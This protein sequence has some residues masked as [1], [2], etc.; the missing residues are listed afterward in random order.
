MSSPKMH[1]DELSIDET[2]VSSLIASQFPDWSDLLLTSVPSAGTDNALFRLGSNMV[3]RLP[4][5]KSAA[6]QVTKDFKWLPKLAPQLPLPVSTPLVLGKPT[7]ALPWN[8][9]VCKWLPGETPI[10]GEITDEERLAV[11]LANFVQSLQKIDPLNGPRPGAHNFGR[12]VP[13]LKR[14]A[15]VRAALAELDDLIDVAAATKEW[16]VSL[17]AA[18]WPKDRVWVHGDLQAGNLLLSKGR[19][20]AVIDFGG[21]GVGDP[22]V[23][24]LPAWNMFGGSARHTYRKALGV[25]EATWTR[26]RGWA[27]SVALIALPYYYKSNPEIVA[28]SLHVIGELLK[29]RE[30]HSHSS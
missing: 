2:L 28:S 14:D 1:K 23:D 7:D 6:G 17:A 5:M 10:V 3:V 30:D 22:A 29:T 8:W 15:Y 12:G 4:R 11:S 18:T 16:E 13:L 27:L 25:D 21:L 9:T 20:S 24:L 19:L 26:G